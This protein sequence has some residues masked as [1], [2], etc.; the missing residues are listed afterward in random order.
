ME[1]RE[2]DERYRS[3]ARAEEDFAGASV[4]IL[5]QTAELLPP[6]RALDLACGAGRNALWLA[7]HGWK[8]TA[9]DGAPAAIEVLLSRARESGLSVDARIA[10]LELRQYLIEP[11][12]WDLICISYY[13]QRDLFEP[14]KQGVVPG[15]VIVALVHLT[16]PG[17]EP[18]AHRVK[19]GELLEYF[20]GWEILHHRE[21]S[22]N[23]PAHRR[24]VVE[25]VARRP[26]P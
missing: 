7:Q 12:A 6:G 21:G 16:E 4:P 15:G 22:P 9:V 24:S 8:V 19:P 14:A 18:T 20:R 11:G 23:D 1:I 13:L 17:E 5:A 3:R 10:D 2:W 26:R 25:V